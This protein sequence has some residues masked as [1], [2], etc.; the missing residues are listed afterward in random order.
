MCECI[1]VFKGI[2]EVS[3]KSAKGMMSEANFLKSLMEMDVDSITQRQTQAVKGTHGNVIFIIW[4]NFI[5]ILYMCILFMYIEMFD[6]VDER[7]ELEPDL[8]SHEVHQ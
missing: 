8:G 6:R 7:Q 3:W 5:I 4:Q 1:V 2:R